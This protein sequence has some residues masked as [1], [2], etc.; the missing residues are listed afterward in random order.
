MLAL[1]IMG[2]PRKNGNTDFLL[3]LFM[4]EIEKAGVRTHVVEVGKKNIMPCLEYSVCERKGTCPIDDDMNEVYS[5]LREADIVVLATPMFFYNAP[6]QTK[7]LIDRSQTLW[8]RRYRLKLSDPGCK[9]KKGFLLALGATKG[10][11]LF[12]GINLTAKYFFDAISASFESSLTYRKIENRKDMENHPTVVDDVKQAAENLLKPYL[13]RKKILFACRENACRSQMASAFARY[14]AGDKIDALSGGSTPAD[15][16]NKIMIEAMHEKGIDMAFRK[17]KSID[18]VL[19]KEKPDIIITMGCKEECPV[20]PGAKVK[21]W[22]IPDPAGKPI[23][24]MRD[25]RDEIEKRIT[26]LI[27]TL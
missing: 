1:G 4:K 23:E 27:S 13:T 16:V 3:S 20:V 19:S 12:E 18:E 8:A 7:A 2:S 26:D 6:G 9:I 21:D 17:P 24:F 5:L 25:V 10:K 14:L 11:N 22:E 15:E